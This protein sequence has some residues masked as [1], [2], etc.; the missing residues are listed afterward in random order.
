M[1]TDT[2]TFSAVDD[3]FADTRTPSTTCDTFADVQTLSAD[4]DPFADNVDESDEE[5]VTE[6]L[7]DEED[8]VEDMA[9]ADIEM[10]S[11][12]NGRQGHPQV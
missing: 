10:V 2:Q 5:P 6:F 1:S 11:E 4:Y 9:P 8:F 7:T 3:P 12:M